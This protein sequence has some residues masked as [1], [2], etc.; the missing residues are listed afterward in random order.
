MSGSTSRRMA[1][2]RMAR[3]MSQGMNRALM[4]R[5]P[6]ATSSTWPR[7]CAGEASMSASSESSAPCSATARMAAPSRLDARRKRSMTTTRMNV[8]SIQEAMV[9]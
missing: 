1:A 3:N 7:S 2:S 5:A 9:T 4:A 6:K 8:M